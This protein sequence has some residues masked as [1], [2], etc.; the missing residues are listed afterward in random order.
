MCLT[1]SLDSLVNVIFMISFSC[2]C[3]MIDG[4]SIHLGNLTV[5]SH[6]TLLVK[7]AQ[8]LS[9]QI[10]VFFPLPVTPNKNYLSSHAN[11]FL[12]TIFDQ[13]PENHV[14]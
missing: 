1:L 13:F 10:K 8:G 4:S 7:Y 9:S 3:M 11:Q 14:S 12:F 6:I 5:G 2:L